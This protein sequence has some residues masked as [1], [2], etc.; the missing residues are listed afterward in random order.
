MKA[1]FRVDASLEIGSGHV[2]RCL[3]LAEALRGVGAQCLFISRAL[4]GHLLELIRQRGFAVTALPAER[5]QPSANT[6]VVSERSKEWAHASWLGC[7]W[8]TDAEETIKAVAQYLPAGIDW[9]VVDHYQLDANWERLLRPHTSKILVIDDLANRPHDCDLL[10]DQ[11]YY[12][13]LEKR[14]HGLV[15]SECVMLLGPDYVLLR[16]EFYLARQSL[17]VRDGSIRHILIFFGGSD[18][19][20]QTQKAIM[21]LQLLGRSDI[22]VDVVIGSANSEQHAIKKMCKQLPNTVFH[23]Q[24]SN[25]AELISKAD[26]G[27]GAGGSAMWERCFLGLPTITVVFAANQER[28]TEDLAEIGAIDYLGWID[29]LAPENYARAVSAMLGNAQKVRHIG[30]TALGVRRPVEISLAKVMCHL[31]KRQKLL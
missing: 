19:T 26:L 28:T 4:P 20:N 3:T 8:R 21:A 17:K 9:L 7:D 25:M 30:V 12:R 5:L 13:D 31:S 27:I 29:H 24:V 6:E 16:P 2:M 11:N 18:P 14:Y 1:A 22:T 23:C 10:L 15:P